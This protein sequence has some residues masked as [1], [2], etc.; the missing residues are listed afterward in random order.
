MGNS[1]KAISVSIT[2]VLSY[3]FSCYIINLL[4]F[5]LIT[6]VSENKGLIPSLIG[7]FVISWIFF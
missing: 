1:L 2:I 4:E 3:G 5:R 6:Y 7:E